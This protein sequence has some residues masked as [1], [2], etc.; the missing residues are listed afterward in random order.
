MSRTPDFPLWR[1]T[2]ETRSRPSNPDGGPSWAAPPEDT[3]PDGQIRYILNDW[4]AASRWLRDALWAA[5]NRDP[6]DAAK[7]AEILH[8]V[9]RNVMREAL[10]DPADAGAGERSGE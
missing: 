1:G 2:V 7:D 4:P 3:D 5:L 8:R 9:L 10:R 6:V